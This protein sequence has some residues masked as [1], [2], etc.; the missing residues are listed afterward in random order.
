MA[1]DA[2]VLNARSEC[3]L[4]TALEMLHFTLRAE[5]RNLARVSAARLRAAT[6]Q[7]KYREVIFIPPEKLVVCLFMEARGM[8]TEK[9]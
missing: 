6:C 5:H 2:I 8:I 9:R 4:L 1:H 3:I 7:A